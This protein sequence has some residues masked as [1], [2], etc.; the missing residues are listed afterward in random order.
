MTNRSHILGLPEI[1]R[2]S[3]GETIT[4]P[5]GTRVRYCL[6]DE[7]EVHYN[8]LPAGVRQAWHHHEQVEE[9]IC[10]TDGQVT[11][12]WI[13]DGGGQQATTLDRGDLVRLGTAPHTLENQST[14][15][16]QF[17]VVKTVPSGGGHRETFLTDKFLD[18]PPGSPS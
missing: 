10:V 15:T 11:L 4:K 1:H 7:Y 5:D 18:N 9:A 12:H 17:V 8:E 3:A 14:S 16:A 13:D 6:F 2:G